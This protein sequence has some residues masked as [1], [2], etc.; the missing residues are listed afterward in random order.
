MGVVS[1]YMS[2]SWEILPLGLND[3]EM[4]CCHIKQDIPL[5]SIVFQFSIV[6]LLS[7]LGTSDHYGHLNEFHNM[8]W[9]FQSGKS[10]VSALLYVIHEWFKELEAGNEVCAIFFDIRKAF[11]SVPHQLLLDKLHA[12]NLDP[13]I[14][15]WIRSYLT[16]RK[17][18]VVVGGHSSTD[19]PVLSGV[20]QES[21]LGPLL[22]FN[23]H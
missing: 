23:L 13:V 1:F 17:Q 12:L 19:M 21:V 20:P 22:F 4:I 5:V 18:H 16:E 7:P 15:F 8:Q 6:L 3:L 14:V 11:D 2:F 10:T 9:G